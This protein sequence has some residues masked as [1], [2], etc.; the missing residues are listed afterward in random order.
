MLSLSPGGSA[1]FGTESQSKQALAPG[2]RRDCHFADT[3][4]PFCRCFNSD[5]EGMSAKWQSRRR[6]L[7]PSQIPH[8]SI[9]AVP[10]TTP[11]QSTAIGGGGGGGGGAAGGAAGSAV[12]GW[13]VT[14]GGAG[15]GA[16]AGGGAG[17]V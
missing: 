1:P 9:K 12:G 13:R 11:L 14:G 7:A 5:G 8:S 6:L 3:P 17:A 16:G 2:R 10:S 4:S 15:A